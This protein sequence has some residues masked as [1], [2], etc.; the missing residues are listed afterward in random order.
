MVK[1]YV[2]SPLFET[3]ISAPFVPVTLI[4]SISKFLLSGVAVIVTISSSV[5][6][7]LSTVTV[8]FTI[9]SLTFTA[10]CCAISSKA[11]FVYVIGEVVP[12]ER[13]L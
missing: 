10:Y 12:V 11:S 4:V 5:A 13:I 3:S 9:L 1:V 6:C 8:P 7:S 2:S